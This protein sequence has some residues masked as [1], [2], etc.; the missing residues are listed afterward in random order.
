MSAEC[1]ATTSR[2]QQA[3]DVHAPGH[4]GAENGMVE[5]QCRRLVERIVMH[6]LE[7]GNVL[8][9]RGHRQGERTQHRLSVSKV[10]LRPPCVR[11]L[12]SI[13]GASVH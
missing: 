1:S 10:G 5:V 8:P 9:H 3:V 7:E 11:G 12:D 13:F 4:S 6:A 2:M